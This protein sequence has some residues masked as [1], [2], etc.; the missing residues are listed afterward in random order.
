MKS[1]YRLTG[2]LHSADSGRTVY[3]FSIL[4]GS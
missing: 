1:S 3:N 4:D 2:A